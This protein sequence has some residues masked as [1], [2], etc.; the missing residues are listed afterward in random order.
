MSI[1]PHCVAGA[2]LATVTAYPIA[3]HYGANIMHKIEEHLESLITILSGS[4][5]MALFIFALISIEA[6]AI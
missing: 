2:T 4:A 3:K 6:P 5:F 1:C